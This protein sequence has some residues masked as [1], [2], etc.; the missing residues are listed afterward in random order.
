M[1]H[2]LVCLTLLLALGVS[3]LPAQKAGSHLLTQ[4]EVYNLVKQEKREPDR[5]EK[6]IHEQ[7]VDFDLN[8][9][10]E[11]RMRKAGATD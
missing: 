11:R 9:D 8:P 10:I 1:R 4:D 7:G 5:L 6:T 3:S 2:R